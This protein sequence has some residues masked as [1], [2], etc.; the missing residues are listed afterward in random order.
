M[1]FIKKVPECGSTPPGFWYKDT[2]VEEEEYRRRS[3][4]FDLHWGDSWY[5]AFDM[6]EKPYSKAFRVSFTV[7]EKKKE[8]RFIPEVILWKEGQQ[9]GTKQWFLHRLWRES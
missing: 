8:R 7:V 9:Y 4:G 3:I 5:D 2:E 6:K 1:K